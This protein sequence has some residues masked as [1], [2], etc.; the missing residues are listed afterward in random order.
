MCFLALPE[1]QLYSGSWRTVQRGTPGALSMVSTAQRRLPH[2]LTMF[3]RVPF[4][5]HK[6][7]FVF[8]KFLDHTYLVHVCRLALPNPQ[9]YSG[10]FLS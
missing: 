5:D 2:H 8:L 6:L 10:V 3:F 4:L 9:H 1:P 7:L